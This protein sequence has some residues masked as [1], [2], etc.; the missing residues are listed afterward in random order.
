MAD[1]NG[2]VAVPPGTRTSTYNN[3]NY[4]KA[5]PSEHLRLDRNSA[6]VNGE[7]LVVERLG[8]QTYLY[9]KI[10]GGDTLIVQ[11]DGDNSSQ[12]RNLVPVHISGDLCHLF[13]L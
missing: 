7:V 6:T 9:V 10:A 5:A 3:P 1:Q 2:W 12:L 11:T 8:G 4:K 13:D